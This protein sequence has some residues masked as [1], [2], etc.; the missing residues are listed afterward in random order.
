MDVIDAP[1][2]DVLLEGVPDSILN[3]RERVYI[4]TVICQRS[5]T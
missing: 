1:N 4:W 2:Q 5:Q 3:R